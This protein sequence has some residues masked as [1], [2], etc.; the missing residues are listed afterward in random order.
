MLPL[1]PGSDIQDSIFHHL[2]N[3]MAPVTADW[4][5]R[6]VCRLPEKLICKL[7]AEFARS[8]K[9]HGDCTHRVRSMNPFEI[10]G[11]AM[12]LFIIVMY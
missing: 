4:G 3:Q 6:Y 9:H 11:Q 2:I 12:R 1:F 5:M 8:A 10:L 7:E